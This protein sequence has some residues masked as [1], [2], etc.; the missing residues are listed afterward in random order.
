MKPLWNIIQF[1]RPSNLFKKKKSKKPG[2]PSWDLLV[3][4]VRIIVW[5][6]EDV[7]VICLFGVSTV[8]QTHFYL[9][10]WI[11]HK[12][13]QNKLYVPATI[14][15]HA[16]LFPLRKATVCL[17]GTQALWCRG[18]E[19][20]LWSPGLEFVL[21]HFPNCVTADKTLNLS[22]PWISNLTWS[23]LH[24]ILQRGIIRVQWNI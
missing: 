4:N 18:Y 7:S 12:N 24:F 20:G 16:D 2:F 5:G 19:L 1:S 3:L 23:Q 11:S 21:Y 6:Q 13:H 14:S 9:F 22:E 10:V 8:S 17:A 15:E